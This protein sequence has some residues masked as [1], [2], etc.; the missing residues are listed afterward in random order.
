MSKKTDDAN[1]FSAIKVLVVDDDIITQKLIHHVLEAFGFV[2][3]DSKTDGLRALSA[4]KLQAYGFIICSWNMQSISGV[5]LVS[6]IRH[7]KD[8]PNRYTPIIMMTGN[9][10]KNDV[11][12]ARDAGVNEFVVKPFT[13]EALRDR[14]TEIVERP[15]NFIISRNFVG[16]DRRRQKK[17]LPQGIEER[18]QNPES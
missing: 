4:T 2:D 17:E 7:D 3:I 15:R 18:R 14:I 10:S 1:P 12:T 6:K 9:T 11:T 16:P 5:E 13:P 8:S